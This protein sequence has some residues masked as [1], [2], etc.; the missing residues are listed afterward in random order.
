LYDSSSVRTGHLV[1]LQSGAKRSRVATTKFPVPRRQIPC[2]E[3][4]LS[5]L[6]LGNSDGFGSKTNQLS[7]AWRSTPFSAHVSHRDFLQNRELSV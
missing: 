1:A 5:L 6:E 4:T 2:F 3:I 7:A